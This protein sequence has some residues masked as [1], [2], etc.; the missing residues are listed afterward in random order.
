[1]STPKDNNYFNI[2]NEKDPSKQLVHEKN[3]FDQAK[4]DEYYAK[5]DTGLPWGEYSWVP[6]QKP[7]KQLVYFYDLQER[8]TK[9]NPL[10]E[11]L[12]QHIETTFNTKSV[13]TWCNKFRNSQDKIDWHQDQYNM[14]LYV[15][16]FGANR[17]VEVRPKKNMLL[18]DYNRPATQIL[19]VQHGDLYYWTPQFDKTM[20][21]R[22]PPAIVDGPRISIL[23]LGYPIN[24]NENP[25]VLQPSNLMEPVYTGQCSKVECGGFL[26][27]AK[28]TMFGTER[29]CK[30]CDKR[31]YF[32]SW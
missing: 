6:G 27:E 8:N 29:K 28:N 13:V 14:S 25:T 23:V 17:P 32:T 16:S 7:L 4:A 18:S 22:V 26:K 30:K 11:G 5:L 31:Y 20:E 3:F 1:M 10:L 19:D 12:I 21:H 2:T 24:S 9:P 15:L